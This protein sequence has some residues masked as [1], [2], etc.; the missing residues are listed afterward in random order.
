V[1]KI[2]RR[3]FDSRIGLLGGLRVE[4]WYSVGW[5]EGVGDLEVLGLV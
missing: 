2:R 5:I 3:I 4:G 1:E